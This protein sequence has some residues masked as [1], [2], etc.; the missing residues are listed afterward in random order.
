[1]YRIAQAVMLLVGVFVTTA[2]FA[3]EPVVVDLWPG[4]TPGDVGISSKAWSSRPCPAR[5]SSGRYR[6]SGKVYIQ[7][8]Q[9][10]GFAHQLIPFLPKPSS[11]G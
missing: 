7:T 9:L 5:A 4:K 3:A 2:A 10:P 6:G 8:R 11:G 1:M